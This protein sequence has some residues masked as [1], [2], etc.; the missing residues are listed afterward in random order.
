[1]QFQTWDL[2]NFIKK[3]KQKK[4]QDSMLNNLMSKDK[5]E[6]KLI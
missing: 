1:M 4:S 6:K 3:K 2:D 5:I